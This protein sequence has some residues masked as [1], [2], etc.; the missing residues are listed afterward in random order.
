MSLT[1]YN[2]ISPP[3]PTAANNRHL[4]PSP[5]H[6]ATLLDQSNSIRQTLQLHAHLLRHNHFQNNP[7]LTLKLPTLLF[8]AQPLISRSNPVQPHRRSQRLP[9]DLN[10]G[11]PL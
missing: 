11:F 8:I 1:N 9:L 4:H 3:P 10:F 5:T 2:F 7:I 6:L